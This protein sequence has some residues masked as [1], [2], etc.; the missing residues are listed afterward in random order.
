MRSMARVIALGGVLLAVAPAARAQYPQRREGFWIGFGLG[1][2]SANITCDSCR[3][4]PRTGGGTAFVQPG[5][6]PPP[7]PLLRRRIQRRLLSRRRTTPTK[8]PM[9]P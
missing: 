6:T 2:G 3:S 1:Y 9:N 7:T 4:G 8:R 5:G